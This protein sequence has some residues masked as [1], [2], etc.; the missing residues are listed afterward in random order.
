MPAACRSAICCG[1]SSTAACGTLTATRTRWD[2]CASWHYG[3]RYVHAAAS[4][5]CCH[6]LLSFVMFCATLLPWLLTRQL[7]PD[8]QIAGDLVRDRAH[9]YHFLGTNIWS[10]RC[11]CVRLHR[12]SPVKPL[13]RRV[14]ERRR[15]NLHSAVRAHSCDQ[16]FSRQMSPS[17]KSLPPLQNPGASCRG[18]C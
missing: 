14:V 5:S 18:S 15:K 8:T 4:F 10:L 13:H 12:I 16:V 2:R 17:C 6:T 7:C 11:A 3:S 1:K 9:F